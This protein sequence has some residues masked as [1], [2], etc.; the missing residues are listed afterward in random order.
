MPLDIRET[1]RAAV[2]CAVM[3]TGAE[4]LADAVEQLHRMF[5]GVKERS[6]S[7]DFDYSSYY[8]EEMGTGLVKQLIRFE[9]LAPLDKLPEIK[10]RTIQL[11]TDL[12]TAKG[13]EPCRTANIDPGMV[14]AQ[15]LILASTKYS[16]HRICIARGLYA[17]ATLLFQRGEC[18]PFEWTYPD[19]RSKLVQEFL[20]KVREEVLEGR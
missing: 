3:A 1:Q 12:A 16:G 10:R 18:S 2:I 20:L 15:S 17:E 9:G 6:P 7:Y 11:E 8:E 5:G 14:S 4:V 19:Y 13:G